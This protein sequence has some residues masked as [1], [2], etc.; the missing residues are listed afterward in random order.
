MWQNS[1]KSDVFAALFFAAVGLGVIIEGHRFGIGKIS[2]PAPGFFPFCGGML[3]LFVS[4]ILLFEALRGSSSGLQPFG[5]LWRPTILA[6]GLIAYVW[7]L[8]RV[9]YLIATMILSLVCLQI[10]EIEKTWWKSILISMVL[11]L[12]SYLLF[13]KLLMVPLP[14]GILAKMF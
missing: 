9:G 7:F 14:G 8:D 10:I 3:L 5:A 11:T 1:K 6:G 12:G 2:E 13:D 4:G